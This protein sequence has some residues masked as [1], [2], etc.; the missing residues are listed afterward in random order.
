MKPAIFLDT[1]IWLRLALQDTNQYHDCVSLSHLVQDGKL[2]PFISNIVIL[3]YVYVLK[4]SYHFDHAKLAKAL[5]PILTTRNLIIIDKTNT[6]KA[7][8][9]YQKYHTKFGD[10]FIATQIP[11]RATMITYDTEFAKFPFL[12][13]KT[14]KQYLAT[15]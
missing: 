10:C 1:N 4:S 6:R 14:P 8:E 13:A 2:Q 11:E 9:L 15:L 5:N 7:L 3:E 12:T